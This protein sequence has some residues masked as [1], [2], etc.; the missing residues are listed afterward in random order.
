MTEGKTEGG[1]EKSL[2]ADD[3]CSSSDESNTIERPP[4]CKIFKQVG[5]SALLFYHSLTLAKKTI[6]F[7]LS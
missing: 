7:Q 4:Y 3:S 6:F 2:V 5:Q 1:S